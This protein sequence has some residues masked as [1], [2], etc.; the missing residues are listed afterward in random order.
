MHS[1]AVMA[2]ELSIRQ[3]F[4]PFTGC[5]AEDPLHFGGSQRRRR[6]V[7]L[8]KYRLRLGIGR[9]TSALCLAPCCAEKLTGSRLVAREER[10]EWAQLALGL[11][12]A[13][14]GYAE[15]LWCSG[16]TVK[17]KSAKNVVD[18]RHR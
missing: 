9:T 12:C 6:L 2:F 5:L 8:G 11:G 10:E 18:A 3:Q 1:F 13:I 17:A 15:T 4:V 16:D 7:R 14:G